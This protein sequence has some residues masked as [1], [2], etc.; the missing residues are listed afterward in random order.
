M[1]V[2]FALSPGPQPILP[3][4]SQPILYYSHFIISM[5]II[6]LLQRSYLFIYSFDFVVLAGLVIVGFG[7]FFWVGR[8]AVCLTH[9]FG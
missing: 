2:V 3:N 8:V 9:E 4:L 7:V 5:N 1:S 6:F